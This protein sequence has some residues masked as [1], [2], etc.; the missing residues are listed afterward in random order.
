MLYYVVQV[1]SYQLIRQQNYEY[2]EV[3]IE[4]RN[5]KKAKTKEQ[6]MEILKQGQT[7][8][9]MSFQTTTYTGITELRGNGRPQRKSLH[10]VYIPC[11]LCLCKCSPLF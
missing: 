7:Y 11:G 5:E 9:N 1:K 10:I 6:M 3:F 4:S 8:L 2:K